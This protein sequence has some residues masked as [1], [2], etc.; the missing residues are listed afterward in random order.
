[1]F[2]TLESTWRSELDHAALVKL[3][4]VERSLSAANRPFYPLPQNV[5]RAFEE[6]PFPKVKVVILGQDPYPRKGEAD[7]LAFSVPI[8]VR[9]PS[10]LRRIFSELERDLNLHR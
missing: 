7:G 2:Q 4:R 5:L 6:T 1:M 10:S 3:A 8:G 9:F